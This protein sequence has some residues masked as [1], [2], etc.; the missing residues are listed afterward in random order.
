D[1]AERCVADILLWEIQ[2]RHLEA[3]K[4]Q[5]RQQN[6]RVWVVTPR[7]NVHDTLTIDPGLIDINMGYGYMRAADVLSGDPMS[8]FPFAAVVRPTITPPA[9]VVVGVGGQGTTTASPAGT[10][11]DQ[12]PNQQAADLADAITLC[13]TR[14]WEVE[15]TAFGTV[16]GELPFS[17]RPSF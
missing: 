8:G 3:A 11:I 17:K 4:F 12:A 1:I 13:R 5:A 14:C 16:P 2:E 15:H 6:K 7:I 10:W 9:A